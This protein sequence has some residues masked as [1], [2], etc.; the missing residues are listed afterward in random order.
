MQCAIRTACDHAHASQRDTENE[1]VISM[2]SLLLVLQL[3][4]I[5]QIKQPQEVLQSTFSTASDPATPNQTKTANSAIRCNGVGTQWA[6]HQALMNLESCRKGQQTNG[7]CSTAEMAS[8]LHSKTHRL[9]IQG[10]TAALY[11]KAEMTGM[12]NTN[13]K[14]A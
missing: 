12:Q 11:K 7:Q 8:C 5:R 3:M 2:L 4:P 14:L 13:Q 9:P 1:N 6:W 10:D